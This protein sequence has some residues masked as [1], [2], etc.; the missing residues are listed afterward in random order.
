[1][2]SLSG[3]PKDITPPQIKSAE[4]ENAST[5]FNSNKVT[6]VFDEYISLRDLQNKM[7]VSPPMQPKPEV[8]VHG[9]KLIIKLNADSLQENKTYQINFGNSIVDV[10]EGNPLNGFT[11]SFSTGPI[12]DSLKVAGNIVD[13]LSL[14]PV[15]GV[16]V[17]LYAQNEKENF[18]SKTPQYLTFTDKNGR[19]KIEHIAEGEYAIFALK[20]ANNN[21]YFDQATEEIAF[22]DSIIIP[23][24]ETKI[25]PNDSTK[26]ITEY[27]PFDLN[28]KLFAEDNQKQYI[29]KIERI[30]PGR[31]Q[32]TFDKPNREKP[33]FKF[34]EEIEHLYYIS[35]NRDSINFWLQ[36]DANNFKD[37]II[38]YFNY[39]ATNAKQ[40]I[41]SD[42]AIAV[43]KSKTNIP[44]LEVKLS[45]KQE[46]YSPIIVNF[47][48]PIS[49]I[50]TS[51]IFLSETKDK[52]E[53][54]KFNCK[55][56]EN[57][58]QLEI[59]ADVESGTEYYL[60][61]EESAF[62]DIYKQNNTQDTLK[63]TVKMASEYGSLIVVL[64][65]DS[66][67]AFAELLINEKVQRK[68]YLENGK[69]TFEN[70]PVG[71]YRIRITQDLNK[72]GFWDTGNYSENLQPEPVFYYNE[73]YEIRSNWQHEL[74]WEIPFK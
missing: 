36:E 57:P 49:K 74:E 4:P 42:T 68:A 6:I 50:D 39:Y 47:E 7:I 70:I 23:N 67:S 38:I 20:D 25:S 31:I 60:F 2:G 55:Q 3:G 56:A 44:K 52:T 16:I 64:N 15:E 53:L 27:L 14:K 33:E 12:I 22:L 30:H 35:K 29:S 58:T 66:E 62:Q 5:N 69:I 43:K 73:E 34:S 61:I 19:F 1:M 46:L 54:I 13:A 72:N 10:N 37:S 59:N 40:E 45:G 18:T 32:I 41:I 9:K 11:Y 71:K 24:V 21:Y 26:T 51:K 28:L 48:N 17:S 63:F 65:A 8:N